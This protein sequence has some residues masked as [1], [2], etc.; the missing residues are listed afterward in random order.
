MHKWV[1]IGRGDVLPDK[2]TARKTDCIDATTVEKLEG[3]SVEVDGNPLLFLLR[4]IPV[5][6]YCAT[7]VSPIPFLYF[8][9][10]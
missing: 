6:R 2:H 4:P 3:T 5:S 9:V 8:M 1:K 7:N 10:M